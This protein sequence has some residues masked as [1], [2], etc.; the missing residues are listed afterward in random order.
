MNASSLHDSLRELTEAA[1]L[2]CKGI[3]RANVAFVDE[4]GG[5]QLRLR[6]ED[7]EALL[8]EL[9]WY[10]NWPFNSRE[11]NEL[12]LREATTIKEFRKQVLDVLWAIEQDYGR[13]GYL[14][15][16]IHH[17]FPQAEYDRLKAL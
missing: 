12:I 2:L 11:P 7:G 8:L 4:P 5:H 14:E 10:E 1:L 13:D 9:G 15:A 6:S 3:D 17:E 16:W